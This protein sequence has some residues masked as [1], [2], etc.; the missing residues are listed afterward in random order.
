MAR[1]RKTLQ[2]RWD[3][4]T[5]TDN[6]QFDTCKQCKL[7]IFQNDG[8][9]WSNNYNKCSCQKYPYPKFKPV[10]IIDNKEKCPYRKP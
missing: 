7:C 3:E 1:K 4:E 8:T 10:E 6:T 2:E 5:L 9:I